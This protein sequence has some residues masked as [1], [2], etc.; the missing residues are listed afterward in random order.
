VR[1]LR[2][3]D[4]FMWEDLHRT[5]PNIGALAMVAW[6]PRIQR[7]TTL[8]V[9]VGSIYHVIHCSVLLSTSGDHRMIYETWYPFDTTKSPAYELAN[10]AQVTVSAVKYYST[11]W[12]IQGNGVCSVLKCRMN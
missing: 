5:N 7:L 4:A 10:I 6:I 1:M 2:L 9:V 3:T 8:I 12:C 11:L